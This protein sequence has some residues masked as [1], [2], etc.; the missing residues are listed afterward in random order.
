[1]KKIILFFAFCSFFLIL[2][3][4]F[5][6][7]H[8]SVFFNLDDSF[9]V[10]TPIIINHMQA[11]R[12]R[13]NVYPVTLNTLFPAKITIQG[14][15]K[16]VSFKSLKASANYP[17]LIKSK[18]G[19]H[20]LFL[21]TTPQNFPQTHIAHPSSRS[22]FR[23]K[24]LSKGYILTSFHGLKC[25]SP[26][27]ATIFDTNG[28]L[29]FYRGNPNLKYSTFHLQQHR[30]PNKLR[31]SMHIQ[32]DNV[33][34]SWIRGKHLLMNEKF[35]V[36]DEI[37]VLPTK[38]HPQIPAD[39]HE[40]VY[41][42]DGHYI[43]LGYE[44]KIASVPNYSDPQKYINVYIQEQKN[45]KVI[46]EWSSDHFPEL[47]DLC[48]EK[49]IGYKGPDYVHINSVHIDPNDNNLIVSA[50]SNYTVF[51][52]DRKTGNILWRLGGKNDDFNLPETLKFTRQHDAHITPDGDLIAFDNGYN[53]SKS[54]FLSETRI[55]KF[56][57]DEKNKSVLDYEQYYPFSSN[58]KYM[59]SAQALDNGLIF[60][61]CGSNDDCAVTLVDQY[62]NEV[63]TLH[64]NK[65]YFNYRAYFVESLQQ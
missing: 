45:G 51:K 63:F 34:N 28:K 35:D 15:T 55:S 57:L 60:I 58:S 24:T 20:L 11:H 27:Y 62:M 46:F 3:G 61:G 32:T 2:C 7:V 1:M 40:F 18:N 37:Q 4:Y 59:G 52:L 8:K 26:S 56:K 42:D 14:V 47:F 19:F 13:Q 12:D 39:E 17:L 44:E 38:L 16:E 25:T 22:A 36:I 9:S 30:L 21:H 29:L 53:S 43:V 10:Q 48:V 31:Y 65:P 23:T 64:V 50:A 41:I 33:S 49:C 5:F 6:N 54:K